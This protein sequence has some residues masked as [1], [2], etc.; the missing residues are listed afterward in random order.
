MAYYNPDENC[1]PEYRYKK[2][3]RT[4]VKELEWLELNKRT[5][6]SPESPY[7]WRAG[8][9]FTIEGIESVPVKEVEVGVYNTIDPLEKIDI[10][11][12]FPFPQEL[13]NQLKYQVT[14]LARFSFIFNED[15][16][17]TGSDE[18]TP[19]NKTI[20]KIISVNDQNNIQQ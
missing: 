15:R 18:T 6:P 5:S 1:K 13:L 10:D 19:V 16:Q 4:T 3:D 14:N 12:P 17:N 9:I 7:F 11:Q 2:I 8:D 20:P